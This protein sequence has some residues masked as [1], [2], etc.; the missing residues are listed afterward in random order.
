[1]LARM[2]LRVTDIFRLDIST[3]LELPLYLSRVPAGFPSPADDYLDELLDLNKKLVGNTPATF[4]VRAEGDSMRGAG[5]FSGDLL[6]VD[7]SLKPSS[8]RI[9][10]ASLNGELL[11]K[12]FR[13]LDGNAYLH[14]ENPSYAP[15]PL[16]EDYELMIWGVVVHCIH[17]L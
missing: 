1:M 7:R 11:V 6:I 13:I 2:A 5:I 17:S 16:S 12:R 3:R 14:S 10:V 9:V 15:I 8:G 4:F